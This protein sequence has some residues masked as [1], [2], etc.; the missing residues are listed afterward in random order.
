MCVSVDSMFPGKKK[1]H[2]AERQQSILAQPTHRIDK[3]IDSP[4]FSPHPAN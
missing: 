4:S 1:K 2:F 3:L